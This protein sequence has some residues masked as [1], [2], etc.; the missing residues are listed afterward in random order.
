MLAQWY[1]LT[2]SFYLEK[3]YD[4]FFNFCLVPKLMDSLNSYFIMKKSIIKA[5]ESSLN[6][7]QFVPPS[8]L[9]DFRNGTRYF[10]TSSKF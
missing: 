3:K 4:F 9:C 2:R 5:F 7:S 6:F 10:T 8:H 1:F